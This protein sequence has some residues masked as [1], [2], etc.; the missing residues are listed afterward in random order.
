MRIGTIPGFTKPRATA[1]RQNAAHPV[2]FMSSAPTGK[3]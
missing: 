1:L 3:Y 2:V